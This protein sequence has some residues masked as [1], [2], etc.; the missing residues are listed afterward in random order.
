[1]SMLV[2]GLSAAFWG[3]LLLSIVVFVHEGGHYVAARL[4]GV[5][6]TEFYLGL[7]CRW[8]LF[9]KSRSH[10]TEV[11]VTPFL[12]GGYNRICGMEPVADEDKL[13]AAL[14]IVYR[15]G[16]VEAS[17]VAEELGI[18]VDDAYALLITL[19][20]WAAI[21]PYYNEE[22]GERPTQREYPQAF[23]TLA[24]DANMLTEYD[25]GH[26][27]ST[28]GSTRDGEPH[29]ISNPQRIIE[30]ERSHTYLGCG[31]FK[32]VAILVAGPLVNLVLAFVLVTATY[33]CT[34]FARPID[35]NVVGEVTTESI[36][37]SAGIKA[38]DTIVSVAGVDVTNWT[39]ASDAL[40]EARAAQKDFSM[41]ILRD[42]VQQ[43]IA[44]DLPEGKEVEAI[45]VV[46]EV[47]YYHLTLGEAVQSSL[48]YAKLVAQFAMRLINPQHTMEVLDSSTSIVGISVMA[49][50]A[51]S[52]GFMDLIAFMAAISMSLGFM[53]LLPIPPLDGGKILIETIQAITRRKLSMRV[54]TAI[55]YVGL[56]FFA[57]IFVVVLRNDVLRFIL[58]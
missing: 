56:A 27:F 51:A 40:A 2:G 53:N 18:E 34:E 26:D 23:E 28:M 35:K 14:S 10:G 30:D 41:V 13:P 4:F 5:R 11:G 57:F 42:G 54:Q 55:S 45:G 37:E 25:D 8:K 20:D 19:S 52:Q 58:Q 29:P 47:E 36:A 21:R 3:V 15:E 48:G 44:I 32:R 1:M 16:R 22:L 6:V 31:F 43:T 39:E 24:R 9:H 46:P 50:Q 49:S 33:L 12:L 38:G 17:K 7:P